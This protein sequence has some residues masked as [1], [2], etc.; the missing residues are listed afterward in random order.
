MSR[1]GFCWVNPV[2]R[3]TPATP[4]TAPGPRRSPCGKTGSCAFSPGAPIPGPRTGM[5][6]PGRSPRE[7]RGGGTAPSASRT[8]F[9]RPE[10]LQGSWPA[11]PMIGKNRDSADFTYGGKYAGQPSRPF[12]LLPPGRSPAFRCSMNPARIRRAIPRKG[13]HQDVIFVPD[14]W[15]R[16]PRVEDRR[17]VVAGAL[18]RTLHGLCGLSRPAPHRNRKGQGGALPRRAGGQPPHARGS[19]PHRQHVGQPEQPA[20]SLGPRALA[21]GRRVPDRVGG[22]KPQP[23]R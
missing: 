16:S 15:S 3:W 12:V 19:P 4:P 11:R 21:R 5:S 20:R 7:G 6:A 1:Y 9:F 2:G 8:S 22:S 18:S 23:A 10:F 14:A 17:P 13:G